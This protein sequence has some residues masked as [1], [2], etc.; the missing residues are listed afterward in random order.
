MA[1][2]PVE[3]GV[4]SRKGANP[5]CAREGRLVSRHLAP[6]VIGKSVLRERK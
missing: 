2:N 6:L 4:L 5:L 1:G 3:T